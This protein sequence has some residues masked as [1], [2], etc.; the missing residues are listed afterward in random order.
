MDGSTTDSIFHQVFVYNGFNRVGQASP[1]Q[2]LGRTLGTSLFSQFEP[3]PAWNRLLTGGYGHDTGWLLPAA[4]A[5]L[6]FV[7]VA[8][9]RA[10]RPTAGAPAPCC[11]ACGSWCLPS[12]SRSAPP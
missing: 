3:P 6:V 12:S 1:N 10:P 9:R 5:S 4:L 11:G 8:R 2:Q 7:L